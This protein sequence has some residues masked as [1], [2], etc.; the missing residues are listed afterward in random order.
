[1]YKDDINGSSLENSIGAYPAEEPPPP[2]PPP[3]KPPPKPPLIP[4]PKPLPMKPPPDDGS[5]GGLLMLTDM[6]R[7]MSFR[8]EARKTGLYCPGCGSMRSLHHLF[9][10]RFVEALQYNPLMVMFIPFLVYLG[11]REYRLRNQ[12]QNQRNR[13]FHPFV[14]P[15]IFM[16]ILLYWILRNLPFY[17]F[18]W[19]APK[20][21]HN[22]RVKYISHQGSKTQRIHF[23]L[24]LISYELTDKLIG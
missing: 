13:L 19:L 14:I 5:E 18:I 24:L 16:L 22:E 8:V 2:N 17:P 4:P 12:H 21:S 3:E 23:I 9:H 20:W 15:S 1:M 11:I 6:L 7:D 10:G